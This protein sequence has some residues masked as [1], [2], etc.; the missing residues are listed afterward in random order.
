MKNIILW[1]TLF[2]NFTI[3]ATEIRVMSFNTTCALCNK[4]QFDKFSKR[5]HW[6]VDT[7]KRNNPDIISLQE[8]LTSRQLK[9][10]AKQLKDYKLFYGNYRVFKFSDSA[11]LVR[12]DRF[13]VVKDGGYWL[14]RRGGKRFSFGWSFAL[15]RRVQWATMVDN[16]TGREFTFVGGHFDNRTKNKEKSAQF[17]IDTF[18]KEAIPILFAGDTNLKP[19]TEGY[20]LLKTF[21]DDSFDLADEFSMIRNTDTGLNDGCNLEKGKIFP[22]CRVDH[23]LLSS[24]DNWQ[25]SNWGID[26]FK[27]DGKFTSD[28]RAIFSDI[29]IE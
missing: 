14:G 15:P 3:F 19:T 24:R 13:S 18:S 10:I 4:G 16:K 22:D 21:F 26:Q 23:I 27:Y 2:F 25:V 5:K 12:R 6:I 20:S 7:I 9:W 1:I 8:V 17:V 29:S 11:L 28:H